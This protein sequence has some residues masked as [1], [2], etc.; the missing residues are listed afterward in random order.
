MKY[1]VLSPKNKLICFDHSDQVAEYCLEKNNEALDVYCADQEYT[2]ETMTPVEIG[3]AYVEA[4]ANEGSC[5]IFET[6]QV[7]DAMKE[8]G[9]EQSLIDDVNNMFNNRRLHQEIDCPSY[10]EDVFME[11]TPIEAANMT[12]GVYIMDNVDSAS[13][14]RNN[15]G[16]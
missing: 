15:S 9:V 12:D 13:D 3:Y 16:V 5:R 14:E 4:V 6:R 11:L 10:L 2:Y 1:V 7:I 8:N